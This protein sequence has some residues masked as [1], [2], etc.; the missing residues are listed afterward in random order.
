MRL[1]DWTQYLWPTLANL[2]GGGQKFMH[3]VGGIEIVAALLVAFKPKIGA[4]IVA[5]WLLGI[6]G[7][8]LLLGNFYDI[9]LRDFGLFLGALALGRLTDSMDRI[10]AANEETTAAPK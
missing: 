5:L 3:I 2:V 10:S 4:Y 9:A 1:T 8:L 7:N 6:I